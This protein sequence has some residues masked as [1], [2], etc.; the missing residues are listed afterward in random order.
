MVLRRRIRADV[1]PPK[2]HDPEPRGAGKGTDLPFRIRLLPLLE[3]PVQVDCAAAPARR[4]RVGEELQ[5]GMGEVQDDSI[6]RADLSEHRVGVSLPD[7]DMLRPVRRD[8]RPEQLN[9]NRICV[10]CKDPPRPSSFRDQDRIRPDACKRVGDDF[11]FAHEVCDS[12]SLGGEPRAEV[13][14]REVDPVSQPVLHVD[15]R[16]PSLSGDDPNLA[17]ASLPLDPAVLRGDPDLRVPSEDGVA[18]RLPM[19]PKTLRDFDDRDIADDVERTRQGSSEGGRHVGH[20]LVAPDRHEFLGELSLVDREAE[21]HAPRRGQQEEIAF[22]YDT[23]MLQEEAAL[24][25]LLPGRLALP[26]RDCDAPGPHDAAMPRPA[27][28][29]FRVSRKRS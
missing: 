25:E 21:V 22:P 8:V 20:V 27:V 5:R 11:P 1:T 12:P 26:L 9:C 4:E 16:G 29:R 19:R 13:R 10:R 2:V 24:E 18:D 23:E 14:R 17:D 6:D 3:D 7:L 15:R 28:K